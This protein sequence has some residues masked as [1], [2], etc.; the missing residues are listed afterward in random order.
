MTSFFFFAILNVM[1]TGDLGDDFKPVLLQD[2][3]GGG[4]IGSLWFYKDLTS[5]SSTIEA[6]QSP[7]SSIDPARR[8]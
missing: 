3:T 6:T 2:W 5:S 8:T 4:S 1:R 7:R